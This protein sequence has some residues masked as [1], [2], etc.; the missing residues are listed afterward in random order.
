MT[1][2]F[3]TVQNPTIVSIASLR[4]DGGSLTIECIFAIDY[5]STGK[6]SKSMNIW[7]K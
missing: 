1:L 5:W 2:I 3:L 4:F 6:L 7:Y